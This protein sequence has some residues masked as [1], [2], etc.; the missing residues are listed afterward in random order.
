MQ[1]KKIIITA[2]ATA[3]LCAGGA[4]ASQA[5]NLPTSWYHDIRP[6][7]ILEN[8]WTAPESGFSTSTFTS[9]GVSGSGANAGTVRWNVRHPGKFGLAAYVGEKSITCNPDRRSSLTWDIGSYQAGN[10]LV[11]ASSAYA[12]QFYVTVEDATGP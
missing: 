6:G 12:I 7:T 2:L 1:K 3:A 8:S 4:I 10:Q 9:C 11:L 5:Q